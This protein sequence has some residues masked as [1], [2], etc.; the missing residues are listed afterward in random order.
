MKAGIPAV[1]ILK[2]NDWGGTK[3]YQVVCECG[4]PGHDHTVFVESDAINVTVTIYTTAKSKWW[5]LN[6]WKKMWILLTRGYIEYEADLIMNEQQAL[7]YAETIKR[8]VS[9]VK[10]FRKIK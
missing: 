6:R 1:G 4:D 7:N 8:A 10:E 5:Q 2:R 9:D 3:S